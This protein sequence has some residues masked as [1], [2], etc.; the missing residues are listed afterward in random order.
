MKAYLINLDRA[1]E[2]L[3]A[4]D[5][6]L[7]AAGVAYER[8]PALDGRALGW[9]VLG[10]RVSRFRFTLVHG[11]PP[12]LGAAASTLSH[13]E[14][15]RRFLAAGEPAALIFEDDVTLDPARFRRA[16][17]LIRPRL[18]PAKPE[19]FL[20]C[21]HEGETPPTGEGIAPTGPCTA[22]AEAY[23]ITAAAA[24]RFLALNDPLHAIL[25]AWGHWARRGFAIWKVYP[26]AA[27]QA[28]VPSISHAASAA[29]R[30]TRWGWYVALWRVR[31]ALTRALDALLY[32]VL[33]L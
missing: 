24:R 29:S 25:D 7:R 31:L 11:H 2:R 8:I 26:P 33:G 12:A 23:V 18:D 21:D 30:R 27:T 14:A 5:A 32:K 4:A 17:D 13:H 1:P 16:L 10:P 6:Q 20:L 15:Y 9:A 19:L 3:A 28:D 22:C